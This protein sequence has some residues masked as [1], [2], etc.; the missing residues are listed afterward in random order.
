MSSMKMKKMIII[1]II[2]MMMMMIIIINNKSE[3]IKSFRIY[4]QTFTLNDGYYLCYVSSMESMITEIPIL[5]QARRGRSVD[6]FL[7]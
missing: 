6:F 2:M 3:M 4:Q 7:C 5:C 1:I